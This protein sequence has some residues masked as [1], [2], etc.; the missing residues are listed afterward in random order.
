M[1]KEFI[2]NVKY[3]KAIIPATASNEKKLTSEF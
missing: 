2:A 3:N 1:K